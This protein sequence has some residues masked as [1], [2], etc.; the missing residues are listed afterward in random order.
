MNIPIT[1]EDGAGEANPEAP[2]SAE[3]EDKPD[4][5]DDDLQVVHQIFMDNPTTDLRLKN[6][7]HRARVK[8]SVEKKKQLMKKKNT[9]LKL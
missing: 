6:D 4:S 5:E 1:E 2:K 3:G 8:A 7:Q 9:I